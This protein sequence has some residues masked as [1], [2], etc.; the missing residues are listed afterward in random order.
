MTSKSVSVLP[1]LIPKYKSHTH[2][3]EP[4]LYN[5]DTVDK[6]KVRHS[7]KAMIYKAKTAYP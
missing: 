2:S 1:K 3:E 5:E 6:L 4:S 7:D